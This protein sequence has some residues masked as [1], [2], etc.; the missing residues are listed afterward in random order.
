MSEILQNVVSLSRISTRTHAGEEAPAPTPG[1]QP[2]VILRVQV[3]GCADL[4]ASD[5]GG[6]S[7]PYVVVKLGREQHKTPVVTRSLNPKYPQK[8]ATFDFFIY[9]S[10]VAY[11]GALK[12]AVW[13]EDLVRD[14]YLGEVAIPFD[15]WFKHH[16]LP[17]AFGFDDPQNEP[18]PSALISSRKHIQVQGTIQ[19]K[20]GFAPVDPAFPPSYATVFS[21]LQRLVKPA[22]LTLHSSMPVLCSAP[23]SATRKEDSS[24]E[25]DQS[26]MGPRP[27]GPEGIGGIVMLEI[28]GAEGL[29]K[30][31]NATRTYCEMNPFCVISFGKKSFDTRIVRHSLKP[32]WNQKLL[33]QVPRSEPNLSIN[34]HVLDYNKFS[35]TEEVGS[36]SFALQE[37][38]ASV[39]APDPKT[40]IYPESVTSGERRMT[41]YKRAIVPDEISGK[42]FKDAVP[43]LKFRASYQPYDALRQQLW[44]QCMKSHD[45]NGD[46][47]IS[48]GELTSLLDQLG[49]TLSGKSIDSLFNASPEK[50]ELTFEQILIGLEG[51][52]MKQRRYA[53]ADRNSGSGSSSNEVVEGAIDTTIRVCPFCHS[54]KNE[55]DILTHFATF[56]SSD[57]VRLD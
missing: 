42:K 57:W 36:V 49:T 5:W 8:K 26:S 4:L 35:R 6:T 48:R 3:V 14:D 11:L 54:N 13:D 30:W 43:V 56:P 20:L 55:A 47:R 15:K 18:F 28:Q 24:L 29:P 34:F 40:M 39:P 21:E 31:Y 27:A 23:H 16:R 19:L 1:E 9:R 38:M 25:S 41:E 22:G 17:L 2:L 46:G 44:R 7:D 37:L 33:L 52:S 32:V 51:E 12:F 50:G 10:N 45:L 53:K